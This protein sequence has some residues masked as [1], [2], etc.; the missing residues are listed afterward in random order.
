MKT[1]K[2]ISTNWENKA[3]ALFSI[4]FISAALCL[5]LF[6][7]CS[8]SDEETPIAPAGSGSIKG[9]VAQDDGQVYG[10]V[11]INLL[12]AGTLWSDLAL[13]TTEPM[14]LQTF[15]KGHMK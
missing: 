8:S 14:N 10:D 2:T 1:S 9:I 7:G 4:A 5:T 3:Q 13:T 11:K 12:Q 15:Q 6:I